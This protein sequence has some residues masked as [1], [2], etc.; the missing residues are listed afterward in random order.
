[1]IGVGRAKTKLKIRLIV[2][3]RR[4]FVDERSAKNISRKIF[5]VQMTI[6]TFLTDVDVFL[7]P[8]KFIDGEI[9]VGCE[10]NA[11]GKDGHFI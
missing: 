8:L 9:A 6:R 7:H 11:T 1:M 4:E 5:G 3:P 2:R 10:R